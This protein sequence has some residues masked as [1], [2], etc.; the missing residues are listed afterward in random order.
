MNK[1]KILLVEDTEFSQLIISQKLIKYGYEFEIA[2]NGEEALMQLTTEKFDLVL[3]DIEMPVL[4]GIE[5]TKIIR[6]SDSYELKNMIIVALT[7]YSG[8]EYKKKFMDIGFNDLLVKP[9]KDEDFQ[10]MMNNVWSGK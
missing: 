5:A 6:S 3:M 1:P 7:A 4:N 2:A 8:D 9:F 10:T